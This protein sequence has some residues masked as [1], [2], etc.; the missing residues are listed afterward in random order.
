M[1]EKIL[2]NVIESEEP[3]GYYIWKT[4]YKDPHK[5]QEQNINEFKRSFG[6]QEVDEIKVLNAHSL[7]G[8]VFLLYARWKWRNRLE[9]LR[10]IKST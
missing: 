1:W 5:E 7:K 3:I 9:Y 2:L 8:K 6:G 10:A 4:S